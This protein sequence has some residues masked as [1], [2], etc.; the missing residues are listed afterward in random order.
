[1]PGYVWVFPVNETVANVVLAAFTKNVKEKNLN[2]KEILQQFLKRNLFIKEI[3]GQAERINPLKEFPIR[4]GLY[5]SKVYVHNVLVVGEAAGI[6]NPLTGEG[7]SYALRSGEIAAEVAKDAL[8][9]EDL[10]SANL[11]DYKR[12]LKDEYLLTFRIK[13]CYQEN[14]LRR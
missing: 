9:N 3:L 11:A 8:I 2:L 13:S 5:S 7:I 10:S 12:K 1:M 4:S 14:R 6:T